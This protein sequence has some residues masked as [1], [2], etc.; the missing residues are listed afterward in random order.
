M[1]IVT[2]RDVTANKLESTT[3]NANLS[4]VSFENQSGP[5][6]SAACRL[7][8]GNSAQEDEHE[9]LRYILINAVH[10]IG[11]CTPSD[12]NLCCQGGIVMRSGMRF[13]LSAK[14]K[15]D[16]WNES[17]APV[18]SSLASILHEFVN[19]LPKKC[20]LFDLLSN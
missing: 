11:R 5:L 17:E 8:F 9:I 6:R 13:G 19:T 20:E 10:S 18:F 15:V 1:G 4:K 7:L 12:V 3:Q 16:V 2:S 14:E